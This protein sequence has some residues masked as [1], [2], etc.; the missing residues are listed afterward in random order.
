MKKVMIISSM[1]FL[2]MVMFNN[3]VMAQV[4][5]EEVEFNEPCSD[6]NSSADVIFGRGVGEDYEQQMSVDMARTS[7]IE[8]LA[9]QLSTKVQSLVSNYRKQERKNTSRESIRRIEG[10]TMTEVDQ[11]TGFRVAC[12]KTTTYMYKGEK[13]YK[14][15]MVIELNEDVILSSLYKKIQK[16]ED[17]KV[18]ADYYS[19]KKEFDEHFKNKTEEIQH[20]STEE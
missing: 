6:Y 11:S 18:D 17:L 5:N 13:M 14:T 16:D 3:N 7:A 8:E 10:L 20:N 1:L 19:F 15:Y 12:R 2:G 4:D 9:S